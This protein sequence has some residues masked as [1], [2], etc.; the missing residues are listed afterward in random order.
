MDYQKTIA[1]VAM[2]VIALSLISCSDNRAVRLRY[3]VERLYYQADRQMKDAASAPE[4]SRTA[5]RKS[6]ADAYGETLEFSLSVLDSISS[7]EH[8]V[9]HREIRYLA[10]QSAN[11]L[12]SLY[13]RAR[14]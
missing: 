10:F 5:I 7:T 14:S 11:R 12:A 1:A 8:P 6:A 4:Q 3:E 9:E 13:F 2:L